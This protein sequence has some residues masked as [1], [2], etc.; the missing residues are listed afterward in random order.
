MSKSPVELT[1]PLMKEIQDEISKIMVPDTS[2]NMDDLV[3]AMLKATKKIIEIR[4]RE[5]KKLEAAG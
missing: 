5:E 1:E 4:T 2:N 3:E